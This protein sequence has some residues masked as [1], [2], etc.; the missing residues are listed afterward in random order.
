MFRRE[1]VGPFPSWYINDKSADWSLLIL[2]AQRGKIG[3]INEVMGVYRQHAGGFWTGQS[4]ARQIENILEAYETYR[5]Y[6]GEEY[7]GRIE[8]ALARHRHELALE[9]GRM[10]NAAI[11]GRL[12]RESK[13]LFRVSVGNTAAL[14][15]PPDDPD[16][17]R[18]TI[19]R[20]ETKTSFDIQLNQPRLR[21]R[22]NHRYQ[23][24][25][26][27]RADRERSLFVGV[28]EAH[29]PWLGLGMY[30]KIELT[31]DWQSIQEEFV[32]T[33][34]EDNARIHFDMGES[35]VAVELTA[36]RLHHLPDGQPVEP[37]S[38]AHAG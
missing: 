30:K 36:V 2:A 26:R 6:L 13:W 38:V 23:L 16:M 20:A 3:Y 31:S 33:A 29:E 14:M 21:V 19:A 9:N 15:F 4:R 35:D 10:G 18:V 1:A 12:P 8:A 37:A 7:T 24:R 22:A 28:A 32:A 5:G 25:F 17:V 27:G 11:A 34:D